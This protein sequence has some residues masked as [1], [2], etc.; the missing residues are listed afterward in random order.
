MELLSD[1]LG[2]AR[3]WQ[4]C[5][6]SCKSTLPIYRTALSV[7]GVDRHVLYKNGVISNFRIPSFFAWV[8]E[9]AWVS[10]Y[11]NEIEYI[12]SGKEHP[13][14][15]SHSFDNNIRLM[16]YW[17]LNQLWSKLPTLL[18]LAWGTLRSES[19]RFTGFCWADHANGRVTISLKFDIFCH[20]C[21]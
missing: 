12:L 9:Q 2:T 4:D 16:H 5:S 13:V 17:R 1:R 21:F 3:D 6:D 14:L 8:H 11:E 19:I 20:T 10:K 15:K 18:E 7:K